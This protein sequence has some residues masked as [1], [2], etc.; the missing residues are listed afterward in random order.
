MN[1]DGNTRNDIA[2]GTAR[3]EFRLPW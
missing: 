1:N 3:N 2:P